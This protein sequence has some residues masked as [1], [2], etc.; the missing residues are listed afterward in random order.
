MADDER[1]SAAGR[2]MGGS[3]VVVLVVAAAAGTASGGLAFLLRND[4]VPIQWALGLGLGAAVTATVVSTLPSGRLTW[5]WVARASVLVL[6]VC[7]LAGA[8]LLVLR[9]QTNIQDVA[10]RPV[11]AA[12]WTTVD[13]QAAVELRV[14]ASA[15]A[16]GDMLTASVVGLSPDDENLVTFFAGTAG[17][18][19]SGEATVTQVVLLPRARLDALQVVALV[20]PA[21]S[22][23]PE[24]EL[25]TVDCTGSM[26]AWTPPEAKSERTIEAAARPACLTLKS[27]PEPTRTV[28]GAP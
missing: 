12:T 17:P 28:R 2:T 19:A 5:G 27:L 16:K 8:L 15:V 20:V 11:V 22:L 7:L 14:E 24:E 9:S 3:V 6:S 25:L 23:E 18:D 1:L 26:L 4:P 21:S 10:A 13:G